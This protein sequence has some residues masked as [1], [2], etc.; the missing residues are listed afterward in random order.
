MI[1]FLASLIF[2]IFFPKPKQNPVTLKCPEFY[3]TNNDYMTALDGW[4]RQQVA[5]NPN[6]TAEELYGERYQFLMENNC[7]KTLQTLWGNLPPGTDPT[8]ANIIKNEMRT[9]NVSQ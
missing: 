9:Y 5:N 8:P 3:S 6:A 2:Y 1:I 4:I 7:A